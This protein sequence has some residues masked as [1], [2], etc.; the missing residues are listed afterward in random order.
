MDAQTAEPADVMDVAI[1]GGGV[2]GTYTGYRLLKADARRSR[3]L[4]PLLAG[5]EGALNTAE[6][7]L[8]S[9]FD[10]LRP[11]WVSPDYYMGP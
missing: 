10:L 8:E 9:K 2:A 4:A 6:M 7:M 5:V 11:S 3:T 1:I